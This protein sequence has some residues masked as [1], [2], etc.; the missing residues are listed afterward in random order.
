[1]TK[2]IIVELKDASGN[3]VAGAKVKA[4]DC[5]ELDS[6][7]QGQVVFLIDVDDFTIDVDG[8]QAHKASLASTPD[9]ITLVKGSGGWKAA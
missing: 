5:W 1:M 8:K 2:R 7:E 3:P 4:T 6:S 9:T